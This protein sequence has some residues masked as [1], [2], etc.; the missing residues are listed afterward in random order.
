MT[1]AVLLVDLDAFYASVELRRRPELHGRPVVVGSAGPRGVV[2]SATYDA[3]ACGVHAGQPVGRARRLCPQAVLLPPDHEE[4]ALASAGVMELLHALARRVEPVSL[5]E[6]YLDL[7]GVPGGPVD[8]AR[9]IRAGIATEQGITASVGIG[10]SKLVAKLAATTAKPDGLRAV[11]PAEVPG[12]LRPLPATGLPGVGERTAELLHRFGLHTVAD[13]ADTPRATL[14]RM[15]GAAAGDQLHRFAQGIDERPV[16]PH[17]AERSLGAEHTYPADTD[18]PE[19]V[20]R[21]LLALA[22]ATAARLRAAH[23][24]ARTVT[25][26]VRFST[27]RT[28]PG[29]RAGSSTLTRS[30][31][32]PEPVD[33]ARDLYAAAAALHR[34]LHLQRARI[35]LVG[36]RAEGLVAAGGLAVQPA[37]G[38]REHGW[39]ELERTVDAVSRR[40]GDGA[41]R[42]ASLLGRG[43]SDPAG[44][45]GHARAAPPVGGSAVH[46][47]GD[48]TG[49]WSNAPSTGAFTRGRRTV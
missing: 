28:A 32:L 17:R 33:L 8:L 29:T 12:F 25:L 31:T 23:L 15:L 18:D 2:L 22:G 30:R 20:E 42:P 1:A 45:A 41:V 7:A 40:F 43:G 26:K 38:E 44:Q 3:R 46:P 11:P 6:A 39:R 47:A 27:S 13:L 4:Y 24:A 14:R 10:P 35:R 19:T 36:V 34:G 48:P 5:D 16:V 21:T 49:E 9:R 37:L